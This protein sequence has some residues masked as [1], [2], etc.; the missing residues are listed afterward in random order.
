MPSTKQ[1]RVPDSS[2]R[3]IER[4]RTLNKNVNA[5]P[6]ALVDAI[7]TFIFTADGDTR[8]FHSIRSKRSVASSL[9]PKRV[10]GDR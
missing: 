1:S 8:K 3:Y 10:G 7:P 4:E 6:K 5:E 9:L 2:R